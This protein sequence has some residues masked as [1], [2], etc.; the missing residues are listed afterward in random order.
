MGGVPVT[1]HVSKTKGHFED[2]VFREAIWE[3]AEDIIVEQTVA[4]VKR[5]GGNSVGLYGSGQLPVE[6][7]YLENI[8]M[9]GVLGS[10]T[11]EANARMCMT[12]WAGF[13]YVAFITDVFDD[14][15]NYRAIS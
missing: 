13:V 4:A 6:G 15:G 7:Q 12:T 1:G 14:Q 5:Y 11:I 3:E 9:K 2:S 8:F 10:N